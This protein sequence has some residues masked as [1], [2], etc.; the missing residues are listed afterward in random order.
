MKSI[1]VRECLNL[2]LKL[3]TFCSVYPNDI[4]SKPHINYIYRSYNAFT[5]F[6]LCFTSMGI[7]SW[8][9]FT[10]YPLEE[11]IEVM[12]ILITQFRCLSR[13]LTFVIHRNGIKNLI[14]NLYNNFNVHGKTF[15][16]EESCI[17]EQT[18]TKCRKITKYYVGLFCCTGISMVLQ[19]LTAKEE[20]NFDEHF[21]STTHFERPLPFK[22]YFPKW[23]ISRSPQYEMEYVAHSYLALVESF[24][25]GSID[26]FCVTI[27]MYIS[28][29]FDLLCIS[30]KN[31]KKNALK[32][33]NNQIS[34]DDTLN[35]KDI[36]EG[37]IIIQKYRSN[38]TVT[39]KT[40]D[41]AMTE[42]EFTYIV[43]CIR[44]HQS[45]L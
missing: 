31:I 19:P 2:N 14:S 38:S 44:H 29:Q 22:T 5:I 1:N 4:S 11:G 41:S 12:S 45:M 33:I 42:T 27:L 10:E 9:I 25:I 7:P 30:L 20:E 17:I 16:E 21:N 32:N 3:L 26:S 18:I 34:L 24:G 23:N 37:S 40:Q 13:F 35:P 39:D 36:I 28:C 15:N 6:L 43:K 8:L